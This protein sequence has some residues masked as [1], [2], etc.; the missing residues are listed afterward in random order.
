[1]E[2]RHNKGQKFKLKTIESDQISSKRHFII[3]SSFI[4]KNSSEI[5]KVSLWG[6]HKING[7]EM[8]EIWRFLYTL[9]WK[10]LL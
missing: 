2:G 7:I 5:P 4:P 3:M 6:F 8:P 1:M 10:Y 9:C